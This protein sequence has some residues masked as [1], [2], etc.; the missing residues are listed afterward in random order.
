M[1]IG[2]VVDTNR[3]TNKKQKYLTEIFNFTSLVLIFK[4]KLVRLSSYV[5]IH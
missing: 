5:F 1:Y 2:K 4:F 3:N